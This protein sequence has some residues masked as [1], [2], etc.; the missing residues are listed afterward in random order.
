MPSEADIQRVIEGIRTLTEDYSFYRI[1]ADRV[2]LASHGRGTEDGYFYW[3]EL[4]EVH[5]RYA[6]N[7]GVDWQGFTD[8]EQSGVIGRA[9]FDQGPT[10]W[11]AEIHSHAEPPSH[12]DNVRLDNL[13]LAD[14]ENE[15]HLDDVA[16]GYGLSREQMEDYY[17]RWGNGEDPEAHSETYDDFLNEAIERALSRM[18]GKG[19]DHER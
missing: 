10:S 7:H 15:R 12:E 14:K 1:D 16:A 5:R 18:E 17:E 11:F 3:A 9:V 2:S 8:S 13:D 6:L 4:E 19:R